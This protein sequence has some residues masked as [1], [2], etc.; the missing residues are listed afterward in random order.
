MSIIGYLLIITIA[1]FRKEVALLG[2]TKAGLN[3]S[4]LSL[5]TAFVLIGMQ[6]TFKTQLQKISKSQKIFGIFGENSYEIYLSHGFVVIFF[7]NI[8][9]SFN[10]TNFF[11]PILYLIILIASAFLGKG[12]AK[13]FSN[14][15][16]L[17]IRNKFIKPRLAV[18][19]NI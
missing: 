9:K 8:Y 2:L 14:P 3:V 7:T 17:F 13:Y 18:G 19:P 16:N 4:I 10:L 5:G 11:I 12:I 1:F 15:I 6:K